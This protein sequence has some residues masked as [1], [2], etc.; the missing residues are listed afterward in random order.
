MIFG[1]NELGHCETSPVAQQN[2]SLR[3]S[4]LR[5]TLVVRI[6]SSASAK[7]ILRSA[8]IVRGFSY[9]AF[10]SIINHIY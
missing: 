1:L 7:T 6:G 10:G 2:P 4:C 8:S 5:D 9:L 3:R